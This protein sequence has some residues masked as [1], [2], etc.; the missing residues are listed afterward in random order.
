MSQEIIKSVRKLNRMIAKE[1]RSIQPELKRYLKEGDY[2]RERALRSR[3]AER[4]WAMVEQWK[5]FRLTLPPFRIKEKGF[6]RLHPVTEENA[7]LLRPEA[8]I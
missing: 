8:Y 5:D 7:Y 3:M 1:W 2:E 4:Q 6:Y